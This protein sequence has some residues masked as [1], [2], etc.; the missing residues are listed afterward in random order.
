[1][2]PSSLADRLRAE[3]RTH[4]ERAAEARQ[5][6]AEHLGEQERLGYSLAEVISRQTGMG[7]RFPTGLPTLDEKT[8]GGIPRGRMVML[9][10]KPGVGKTSLASQFVLHMAQHR[11]VAVLALFADSGIDDAAVTMAQQLGVAREQALCGDP[12][13]VMAVK[14]E[15]FDLSLSLIDPDTPYDIED[16]VQRFVS[17]L[18]PDVTPVALLDSVQVLRCPDP[19]ARTVYERVTAISN[20]VKAITSRHRLVTIL[21]SQSN[22]A[23]Y[24]NASIAKDADPLA[25]G[26][27][28]GALEFMPDV[29]LL[30]DGKK[31]GPIKLL[32]SKSRIGPAGWDVE[33]ALDFDR[34]RH[35]EI[36]ADAAEAQRQAE[37]EEERQ[38]VVKAAKQNCIE[39]ARRN[40]EGLSSNRFETLC[41][42]KA[43]IHRE[44]RRSLWEE[45]VL[46]SE[47]RQGRG[48]GAVWK[49]AKVG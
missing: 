38:K 20:T 45:G 1:M 4:E 5:N 3:I 10:G 27:G 14:R 11:R 44:A 35:I 8:G 19:K 29:H 7:E 37:D 36:D 43:T 41:K 23:A 21:V 15:T 34:H 17:G 13:A 46:I 25:A 2:P 18:P 42:G 40:P 22:R 49:L 30:L 33:L 26:A 16:V 9:V 28:G 48:G 32:C 12:E 6:L 31:N 39:V 47:E 24:A